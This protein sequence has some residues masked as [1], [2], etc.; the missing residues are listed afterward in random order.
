[1]GILE[2]QARE[3]AVKRSNGCC[4]CDMLDHGHGR[5]HGK[6]M[7]IKYWFVW[8]EGHPHI[9]IDPNNFMVVCTGC[10]NQIRSLHGRIL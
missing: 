10:K 4:E 8:K 3:D 7:K 2:R 6:Q 9:A 1:M 5:P